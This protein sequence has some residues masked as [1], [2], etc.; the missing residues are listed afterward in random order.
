MRK[1]ATQNISLVLITAVLA[2]C[3]NQEKQ[4]PTTAQQRVFMRA[5][6]TAPYTEVTNEYH[7]NRH[8]G[9]GIG[10]SPLLWYMAFRHLGGG[11][12]FSNNRLHPSS[13]Y[14]NNTAKSN[15]YA[16][17]RG[18]FGKSAEEKSSSGS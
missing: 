4:Q 12:G 17:Q 13:V 8:V 9:G 2:S 15:A 18:G 16:A 11:M 14:G 1:K 5:D 7:Q 3:N 10:A 6:S